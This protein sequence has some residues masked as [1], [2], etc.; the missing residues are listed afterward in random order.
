[1]AREKPQRKLSPR[2]L[3]PP[4]ST[5]LGGFF[6]PKKKMRYLRYMP[7]AFCYAPWCWPLK[8]MPP[9]ATLAKGGK[10]ERGNRQF[11]CQHRGR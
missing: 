6:L 10:N 3:T 8:A 9:Q 11:V 2:Y 7:P 4:P 5:Y 1:M